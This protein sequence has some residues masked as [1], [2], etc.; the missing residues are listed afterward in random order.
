MEQRELSQAMYRALAKAIYLA[1]GLAILALFVD[2]IS[3]IMLFFLM[4]MIFAIGLSP[5]VNWL[6]SRRV[7]RVFGTLIVLVAIGGIAAGVVALVVPQ[8]S[9]EMTDFY[10]NVNQYGQKLNKTVEDFIGKYPEIGGQL[11]GEQ[12]KERIGSIVP[13]LLGRVGRYSATAVAVVLGLLVLVALVGY[14]LAVP[15]PLLRGIQMLFPPPLRDKFATAYARGS[16]GV[17]NWVWANALIGAIEGVIT[18]IVLGLVIGIPGAITWGVVVFFAELIPQLG[19]YILAIPPLLV[20]LA[21]APEKAIWVLLFF[22]V[23]QQF[24]NNVLA[25]PIRS[26]AM[27][28]HPVSEIFA[29]LALSMAFGFLGAVIASP[30]VVFTKAFYDAF[31]TGKQAEDDR[32]DDRV[33]DMLHRRVQPGPE[34]GPTED[35]APS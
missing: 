27:N 26:S 5:A 24:A 13:T 6:E 19:S 12:L 34:M 18:S 21:V 20:T 7:P 35:L 9:K 11:Q 8:V 15:R 3:V 30:V 23:L 22:I 25:P 32:I 28:I 10:A 14:M 29:V 2:A 31:Y 17:V 16:Q 33:E 1:A 4:A